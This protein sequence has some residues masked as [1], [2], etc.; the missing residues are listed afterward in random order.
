[1]RH[2]ISALPVT[3]ITFGMFEASFR[4]L[5]ITP[6]RCPQ[7]FTAGGFRAV[8][9]T[10]NLPAIAA[11]ADDDLNPAALAKVKPACRFHSWLPSRQQY[12][13]RDLSL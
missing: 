11:P 8:I 6:T 5:L 9:R 4:A 7:C 3:A 1:M 12:L 13:D 10:I 2:F